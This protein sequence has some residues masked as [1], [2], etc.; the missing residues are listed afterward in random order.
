[1]AQIVSQLLKV[2][3]GT[4]GIYRPTVAMRITALSA[5]GPSFSVKLG[6][7]SSDTTSGSIL[8][9]AAD[10]RTTILVDSQI[11]LI[12]ENNGNREHVGFI[13]GEELSG[14]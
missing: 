14:A 1:M 2:R 6:D 4:S 12:F 10:L 9:D 7:L 13:S 3:P 11:N 8:L 5:V